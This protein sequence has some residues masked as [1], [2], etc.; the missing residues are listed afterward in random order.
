[1]K[2]PMLHMDRRV[3]HNCRLARACGSLWFLLFIALQ[4][5]QM[6]HVLGIDTAHDF[7]RMDYG[8]IHIYIYILYLVHLT[9]KGK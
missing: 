3:L 5:W 6:H 1:M 7:R 4:R 8:R 2:D 9:I